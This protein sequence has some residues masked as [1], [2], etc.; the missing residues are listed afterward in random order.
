[1]Q[2]L[3]EANCWGKSCFSLTLVLDLA[4][5]VQI[6]APRFFS[7]SFQGE[8]AERNEGKSRRKGERFL[9]SPDYDIQ[10][11][12]IGQKSLAPHG[13]YTVDDNYN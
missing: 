5:Q 9:G 1:M 10:A 11:L 6:I 3:N 2:G 12:F 4:I 13:R 8:W 7:K